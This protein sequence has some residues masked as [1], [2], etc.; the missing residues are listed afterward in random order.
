MRT[1][2][3]II[4]CGELL[5]SAAGFAALVAYFSP[6]KIAGL[7]RAKFWVVIAG[8]ELISVVGFI[9]AWAFI[10]AGIKKGHIS[11]DSY[12]GL[13]IP[14]IYGAFMFAV[15]TVYALFKTDPANLMRR[16]LQGL[17]LGLAGIFIIA[18][19][20][21]IIALLGSRKVGS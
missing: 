20:I 14:I 7:F 1:F 17:Y 8:A 6:A 11:T 9:V 12:M 4:F 18:I 19:F 13:L 21:S 3:E 10:E 2:K 16:F 5:L 15:A